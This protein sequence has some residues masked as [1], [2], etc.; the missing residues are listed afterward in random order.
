MRNPLIALDAINDEGR[1][2]AIIETLKESRN[3]LKYD[4]KYGQVNGSLD[5]S[6]T[7][8]AHR[9]AVRIFSLK[10]PHRSKRSVMLEKSIVNAG[11]VIDDEDKCSGCSRKC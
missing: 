3:K 1:V 10:P 6:V 11:A 9:I 7:W 5:V 8:L 4:E 2:N